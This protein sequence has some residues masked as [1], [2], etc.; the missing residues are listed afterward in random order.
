MLKLS[1]DHFSYHFL[2]Y[3]T[4]WRSTRKDNF[5][6]NVNTVWIVFGFVRSECCN[7]TVW[8][9]HW[10]RKRGNHHVDHQR[11]YLFNSVNNRKLEYF[12]FGQ[13]KFVEKLIHTIL[14][15]EKWANPLELKEVEKNLRAYS[16]LSWIFE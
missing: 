11:F 6:L 10:K 9:V 13:C 15:V 7:C 2:V 12:A 14:L 1:A 4:D 5:L 3:T 16:N 8:I